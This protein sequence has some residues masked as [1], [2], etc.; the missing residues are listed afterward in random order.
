MEKTGAF[1]SIR[2]DAFHL[3]FNRTIGPVDGCIEAV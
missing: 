1:V 2:S 3:N